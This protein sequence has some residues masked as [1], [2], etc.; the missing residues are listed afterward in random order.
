[1]YLYI[2]IYMPGASRVCIIIHKLGVGSLLT[3]RLRVKRVYPENDFRALSPS[4]LSRYRVGIQMGNDVPTRAR[5]GWRTSNNIL[6]YMRVYVYI[7]DSE[8]EREARVL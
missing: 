2:Y 1:M 3:S 8:R 6:Y 4:L 7:K 5:G